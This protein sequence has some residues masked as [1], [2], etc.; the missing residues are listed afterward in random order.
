MIDDEDA[1]V[2]GPVVGALVIEVD[3]DV[4][5][6]S[7]VSD[8]VVPSAEVP[9][10]GTGS[11][12]SSPSIPSKV[13][14]GSVAGTV[15]RDASP[16]SGDSRDEPILSAVTRADGRSVTRSRTASTAVVAATTDA[17]VARIQASAIPTPYRFI[18]STVCLSRL[19]AG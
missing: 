19:T 6:S 15:G 17:A 18:G 11:S 13:I 14:V 1:A 5:S 8:V 3:D 9:V 2:V 7:A 12:P 4:E 16:T 10:S